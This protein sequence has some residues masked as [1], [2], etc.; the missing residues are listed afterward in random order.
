MQPDPLVDAEGPSPHRVERPSPLT[1]VANASVFLLGAALFVAR[2]A[3]EGN[4]DL[5]DLHDL[6]SIGLFLAGAL[7]AVALLGFLVGIIQWRSTTFIVDDE[8]R[9]ERKL[10][11]KS[12]TQIAF[13]KVQSVDITRPFAARVLRLAAVT[14]DVGSEGSQKLRFL[15]TKRANELRDHLLERMH[16]GQQVSAAAM[17]QGDPGTVVYR[18]RLPRMLLG[19]VL[20]N[21]WL[22][23]LLAFIA[24]PMFFLSLALPG[25]STVVGFASSGALLF[26]VLAT[27]AGRVARMW[28]FTITRNDI[29]LR[30][31]R[32]LFTRVQTTLHIDR[33]QTVTLN[34]PLLLRLAGLVEIRISVLG[35]E[36][37]DEN[38]ED[39]DVVL[40]YGTVEEAR[41]VL[42]LLLP[43][44]DPF[45]LPW[46]R[47]SHK[48][49]YLNWFCERS[50]AIDDAVVA[51]QTR[52][53]GARVVLAPHARVQGLG[54]A[55]GP[56]QRMLGLGSVYIHNI[57]ASPD[58]CIEH[59][60]PD[61]IDWV[62]AS[63]QYRGSLARQART[64][65]REVQGKSKILP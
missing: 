18:T 43:G 45:S 33:I 64:R 56:L 48:G 25:L 47:Q 11:R 20:K 50:F 16:Q 37:T 57:D 58:L 41:L 31:Q 34:Q 53:L 35:K 40:P 65:H 21:G 54:I 38:S 51:S 63:I 42:G 29:G 9:I 8:F 26:A 4:F 5:F 15:T 3:F 49:R 32:G 12:T 7:A 60:E 36:T 52:M 46:I 24:L 6:R 22:G 2:E 44:I 59:L 62:F 14:I 61:M 28:G 30:F 1:G 39:I 55:Q 17:A 10:F 27:T 23:S 13:H 19:S